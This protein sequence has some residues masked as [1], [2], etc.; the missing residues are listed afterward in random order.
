MEYFFKFGKLIEGVSPPIATTKNSSHIVLIEDDNIDCKKFIEDDNIN[1]KILMQ[2]D[3]INVSQIIHIKN[4]SLRNNILNN[5]IIPQLDGNDSVLSDE[6]Y[7]SLNESENSLNESE[8][9]LNESENSLNE[10]DNSMNEY[11]NTL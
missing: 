2:D 1:C 4:N 8:N 9:S 11:E 10:S 3:Y 5:Y 7:N 6:S